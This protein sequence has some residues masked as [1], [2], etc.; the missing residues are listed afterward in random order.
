MSLR[1]NP[2]RHT[3]TKFSLRLALTNFL[4]LSISV[5]VGYAIC[6]LLFLLLIRNGNQDTGF[7]RSIVSHLPAPLRWGYPSIG[8][9]GGTEDIALLGD[10]YVEGAGDDYRNGVADYAIT[11]HLYQKSGL[12]LVSFG[13]NGTSLT[14]QIMLYQL[15]LDGKFW[16]M[17]SGRSEANRPKR[18]LAFFYEGNDLDN[19]IA[20]RETGGANS[21]LN[22]LQSSR[23]LQPLRLF[24]SNKFKSIQ[25]TPRDVK[26]KNGKETL[27]FTRVCGLDYCRAIRPMQAASPSL[28]GQEIQQAINEMIANLRRLESTTNARVCLIY[29]ASPATIYS[30]DLIK[31]KQDFLPNRK[32]EGTIAGSKNLKRSKDIRSQFKQ[33]LL[34]TNINFVDSTLAF[35]QEAQRKFLHGD[36]DEKHFNTDGNRLLATT[37]TNNLNRCFS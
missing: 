12:P 3:P 18:I 29:I 27:Q 26:P 10:S 15:S 19:H 9:T 2:M 35:Q 20:E 24:L 13:T 28:D 21:H 1:V 25:I 4:L 8:T 16:P 5:F 11:H 32:T 6:N 37:V 23:K 34:Q 22:A 7:P 33:K 17:I 14:S 30:P 36:I 31:F